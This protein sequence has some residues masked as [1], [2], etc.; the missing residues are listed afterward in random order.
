[1][2]NE[3]VL[4]QSDDLVERIEV[5]VDQ[6]TVWLSQDQLSSLF[7]RDQSVISRH[8]RNVYKEGEEY[9]QKTVSN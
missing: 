1:M 5:R 9:V 3:I 4:Y 2:S 6:E 7:Q 8:I